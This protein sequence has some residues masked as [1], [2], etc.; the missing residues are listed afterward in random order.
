MN[1]TRIRRIGLGFAAGLLLSA[2]GV[3]A[4]LVSRSLNDLSGP[5]Q[6][7]IDDWLVAEKSGLQKT[8]HAF[9]K[10]AANPVLAADR[11]WEGSVVYLY[12]TVLPAE[13]GP[14]YRMWYHSWAEGEYRKLY[15]T[16]SD[17]LKWE[18]PEL[19]LVDY[20]GSAKN[21]L[22]L[23]RSHED[24]SPQ[25][26]HTPADPDPLR[27]YKLVTYEYGRTPP[28]YTV[29]GY[30]GACSPDGI[31][32]TDV[33]RYPVLRDPGDVGNFTWDPF[34]GRYIGYPKK[35]TEVRGYRRR[36][37]GFSETN[38]FDSWPLARLVLVP[39]EFDDRWV[40][41]PGQHTDFYGLSAFAYESMYLGFLWVF[42]ITDG[43][44]DG[45]IFVEMVTS[46]DGVNWTRQDEPRTPV[47]PTGPKGAWDCGMV[48]TPNHPLV[49]GDKVRLYYGGFDVTHGAD[50]RGA[51]GLAVLRKDGFASLD[52]GANAGTVTTHPL[53]GV[54][55]PL[56]VNYRAVRGSLKVEIVDGQGRPLAGYSRQ[57]CD[58]LTTDSVDQEVTWKGSNHLPDG[59][60]AIQLRFV[61][62]DA[63]LYSFC[64][65]ENLQVARPDHGILYTFEG[66]KGQAVKDHLRADGSQDGRVRGL[67]GVDSGPTQA[68]FGEAGFRIPE[69]VTELSTIEL[70][71]TN[72]LGTSFT[73]AAMVKPAAPGFARL[74]SNYRG[75]G[76]PWTSELIFDIDPSGKTIAGLRGVINGGEVQSGTGSFD[77]GRYHHVALTYSDGETVLYLDGGEVGRG[78]VPAGPVLL[79]TNMRIGEDLGGVVNEQFTGSVDDVLVLR[80]AL[81]S[82][83]I[84]TLAKNGARAFVDAG[85]SGTWPVRP[86]RAAIPMEANALPR[87]CSIGSRLELF[88]DRFL[89]ERLE[90]TELRLHHPQ[91]AGVVF[92]FDRP[93]E[94]IVSGYV[95][96]IKDADLYR[97]YYRGR[98]T[99]SQADA[100]SEA[101]EV[102]C[103]AESRDG[104]TWTRPDLGLLEVAGTRHNNVILTEPKTVTHN[105]CPFIDARPGVPEAE[106]FKAVGGTGSG[107]LF[108]FVSGDGIHWKPVAPKALITRGEFD[109][110]N[111]AFWSPSEQL[112]LCYYRT[113]R[114][115]RRWIS[116]TTSKDFLHWTAPVDMDYGDTPP[117]HLYTNQTHPYFRAPH[118][119]VSVAARFNPGRR[120]LTDEQVK[121]LDLES[122]GNYDGLKEDTSDAVLLTS[123]G[124]KWYDRTFLESFIRPGRDLRNWV[125][126]ANYPALGVVPTGPGEMSIYIQ[127]HYGQPS[128]C[129]ERMTLRTDGF[130]S[131]SASY[132][133]GEMVTKPLTF[134]GKEL[135]VNVSTSAVGGVRVE[136]QSEAGKAMPG[137]SL[138]D[139]D[140]VIGDDLERVMTWKG[141]SDVSMLAGEPVRLRFVMKDADLY[142]L[143]FR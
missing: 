2:H 56:R 29:S 27:Q 138:T 133:G 132:R 75:S 51:I 108:G 50:G 64:A 59:Q 79:G 6:L 105:F 94:G 30:L 93:W 97:M 82:S 54:R 33:P 121:S 31:R 58:S 130:A 89:I 19:G 102:A 38:V 12:G 42:R 25:V 134:T 7:F 127:R 113:W 111:V 17:G 110:Q 36:C 124:G 90:G 73:L 120:A 49:E 53:V 44:N 123:R 4:E 80:R 69:T 60:G 14:G 35:F 66:D 116:R 52:A 126:R 11:P 34:N 139:A 128:A 47:L 21:N 23:K 48:F 118:L 18:K 99:T 114:R 72:Q 15:A 70:P 26:I 136:I 10:Y 96:V 101:Q 112:Y 106:R 67:A 87:T 16:S 86:A 92:H 24:H 20:K 39:D 55:G 107:G 32:W 129:I 9:E 103:Y 100:S 13:K 62:Q 41:S 46:R 65:G 98:P 45:P 140:E 40:K 143:R 68:A 131:V 43:D 5:W 137:F 78:E 142:S 109:S 95:T 1:P 83:E 71:G 76:P 22:F 117:E 74:F 28:K 85:R 63:S 81:T 119:Y 57:E 115:E 8:W 77:A 125:A 3:F 84:G 104:V 37:V 91:S 141:K 88:V 61:L 135:I 122:K